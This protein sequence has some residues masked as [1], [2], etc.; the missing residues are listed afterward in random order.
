MKNSFAVA[1]LMA[2]L[3]AASIVVGPKKVAKDYKVVDKK[4][5]S[6]GVVDYDDSLL[7]SESAYQGYD[8]F[9]LGGKAG[10]GFG[11]ALRSDVGA[12]IR[13]DGLDKLGNKAQLVN[14][15]GGGLTSGAIGQ[16]G[17]AGSYGGRG[18]GFN[19]SIGASGSGF[20]AGIGFG[21]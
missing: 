19:G 14:R 1:A 6:K 8:D 13:P 20:G 4:V 18:I 3:A 17:L 5:V 10:L 15:L 7:S 12:D 9:Y 16:L 2:S 21:E 11:S